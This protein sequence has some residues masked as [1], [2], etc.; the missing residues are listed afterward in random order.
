MKVVRVFA[1]FLIQMMSTDS[2][3]AQKMVSSDPVIAPELGAVLAKT[4]IHVPTLKCINGRRQVCSF[5]EINRPEIYKQILLVPVGYQAHE[6][7]R[8]E[9]DVERFVFAMSETDPNIY[10]RRYINNLLYVSM[11]MPDS[12]LESQQTNFDAK[13]QAHPTRRFMATANQSKVLAFTD[14]LMREE[15]VRPVAV[16]LIY[17]F[18]SPLEE[19]A[20][21]AVTPNFL[22]RPYGIAKIMRNDLNNTYV[23]PHEVAH[24][25][26][27]FLDEYTEQGMENINIRTLDV[28]TPLV[29]LDGSLD[30][31]FRALKN[32]LGV[33]SY[34][35]SEVLAANGNENLDVVSQPNRVGQSGAASP[36]FDYEGGMFFGRGTYHQRGRN[37]MNGNNASKG[38][39]DG[40]AM[41]HSTNQNNLIDAYFANRSYRANDR[42]RLVGPFGTWGSQFG[43]NT[44]VVFF[45]ADKNH[46]VQPTQTY[47]VQ[48]GYYSRDWKVC[49]AAIIP[50][51]CYDNR[52]TAYT[53]NAV[54]AVETLSLETSAAYAV[55][56][57]A[58][59]AFCGLGLSSLVSLPNG[60]DL[61]SQSIES[62]ANGFLPA[63]RFV[64]PYQ[65][66][67]VELPQAFSTY[68]F[69]VRSYNGQWHSNFTGWGSFQRVF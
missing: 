37:M 65:T 7:G 46:R 31:F 4:P 36:N 60:L 30:A 40:F 43:S 11:W 25:A 67:A 39:D 55:A 12:G 26:L 15:W 34:R 61:C 56:Q 10:S 14:R 58:Q 57:L 62:L 59:R 28:L 2:I 19:A 41:T 22:Q 44:Q 23:A 24:A 52:W 50:Y 33:Y 5:L 66:M 63:W 18:D 64:T 8:F 27:N 69:R 45:D 54:A 35:I 17:N 48:V 9:L 21:S 6:K 3:Y 49:W 16:N 38:P 51:P 53:R 29:V 42:L 47:E 20:A 13:L 32:V 68:Y 1:I